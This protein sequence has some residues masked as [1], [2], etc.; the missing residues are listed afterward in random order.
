MT[1]TGDYKPIFSK[2]FE[3]E[4]IVKVRKTLVSTHFPNP[5]FKPLFSLHISS[6]DVSPLS[7]I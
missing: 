2:Q 4:I 1:V 5:N 7:C 3:K 6:C